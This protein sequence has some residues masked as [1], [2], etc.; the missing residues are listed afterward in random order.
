M[1]VN[2]WKNSAS[3]IE[4]FKNIE[5]KKNYIFIKFDVREFFPS[6]AETILDKTLLFPK[7][8]HNISSDTRL[9]KHYRKSLLFSSNEAWTKKQTGTLLW[10]HNGKFRYCR[11]MRTFGYLHL[12]VFLATIINKKYCGL[13]R[14]D[15]L[16]I[17]QNVNGQE[18]DRIRKNIIK[19]I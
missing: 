4:W 18:I 19:N 14:D 10:R 5:D 6:V 8:Y 15:G 16:F 3:V 17:L 13:Y 9:I 7:Q 1:R 12:N 11:G 2:Q